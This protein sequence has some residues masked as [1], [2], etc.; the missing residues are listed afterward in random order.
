MSPHFIERDSHERFR[1]K[2]VR[3]RELLSGLQAAKELGEI[4]LIDA[5]SQQRVDVEK[6][7]KD[8]GAII[9]AI[10]HHASVIPAV[11]TSVKRLRFD[12]DLSIS[13]A[14]ALHRSSNPPADHTK[15]IQ[16][17]LQLDNDSDGDRIADTVLHDLLQKLPGVTATETREEDLLAREY[18][19]VVIPKGGHKY[20]GLT[21][22]RTE[23]NV[24]LPEHAGGIFYSVDSGPVDLFAAD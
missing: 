16:N 1:A 19:H 9:A 12:P 13:Q 23:S 17:N 15:A 6:P 24:P 22:V 18:F 14:L 3:R 2:P 7:I 11:D 8:F 5:A 21:V 10:K 20:R 4:A